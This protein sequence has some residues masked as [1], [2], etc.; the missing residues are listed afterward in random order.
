MTL[1]FHPQT[2]KQLSHMAQQLPHAV[3]ITGQK[4]SGLISTAKHLSAELKVKPVFIFP[5]KDE[6]INRAEG[7]ISVDTI[8]Q[9]YQ[10][11]Q[12]KNQQPRIFIIVDADQMSTTAANAF[13]KLLEEPVAKI[14]FVL[15]THNFESLLPTIRSR[16][17]SLQVRP[18]NQQQS[19]QLLDRLK[20]IDTTKRTQLLFL[21]AGRPSLI[22]HLSQDEELFNAEADI[23]RTAR[24]FVSGTTY[25]RLRVAQGLRQSRPQAKKMLDYAMTLILFD[26][27]RK[28]ELPSDSRHLLKRLEQAQQRLS[29][30]GN[31]RLSIAAALVDSDH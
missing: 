29:Y 23:L 2:D 13:L 6:K 20:V 17:Q 16:L 18:I 31:V 12:G 8:R 26:T 5:E 28:Q 24:S 14:H 1:L 3:C 4:G 7:S 22:T 15:L 21:A 11:T 25:Q 27:K 19:E 10:Q 9:L 30:N